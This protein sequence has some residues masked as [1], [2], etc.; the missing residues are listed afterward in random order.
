MN[1]TTRSKN[2]TDSRLNTIWLYS[3]YHRRVRLKLGT[4]NFNDCPEWWMFNLIHIK[5]IQRSLNERH[6]QRV[7]WEFQVFINLFFFLLLLLCVISVNLR[8]CS[9]QIAPEQSL[10]ARCGSLWHSKNAILWSKSISFY[11]CNFFSFLF[12]A[13]CLSFS[14]SLIHFFFVMLQLK[15]P[16]KINLRNNRIWQSTMSQSVS[17]D[18]MMRVI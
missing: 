12:L 13:I 15:F 16:L 8:V 2:F 9:Q 11:V 3:F 5:Y 18:K 7:E 1:K 10:Y 6:N 4:Y 17:N 14:L